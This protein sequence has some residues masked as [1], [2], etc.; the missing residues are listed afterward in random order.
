LHGSS[1]VVRTAGGS[2]GEEDPPP[3][4]SL[5]VRS[6]PFFNVRNELI[7]NLIIVGNLVITQVNHGVRSVRI[8]RVLNVK[9][10]LLRVKLLNEEVEVFMLPF[11]LNVKIH[12]DL[13]GWLVG[14]TIEL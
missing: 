10:E 6:F 11:E 1:S 4:P 9:P 7:N 14:L 2:A 5:Y 12:C 13:S 8:G 3:S